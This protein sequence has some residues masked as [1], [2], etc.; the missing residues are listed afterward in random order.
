ME[1]FTGRVVAITGAASGIGRA[2][3]VDFARQGAHVALS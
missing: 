1:D 3:A 2:L